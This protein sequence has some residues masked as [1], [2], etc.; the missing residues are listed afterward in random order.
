MPLYV[1][2]GAIV[3]FGPVRQYAREPVDEPLTLQI[4]PG[5]DGCFVLYDGV[6]FR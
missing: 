4:Y 2:A 3:P 1:K 6:S 5:A